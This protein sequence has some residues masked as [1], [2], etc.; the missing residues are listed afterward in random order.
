MDNG[1]TANVVA[2]A[3]AGYALARLLKPRA[4]ANNFTANETERYNRICQLYKD[5]IAPTIPEEWGVT[6]E[7]GHTRPSHSIEEAQDDLDAVINGLKDKDQIYRN[8][9][10]NPMNAFKH[11]LVSNLLTLLDIN[12][13]R[14]QDGQANFLG[15][16]R[17]L[18]QELALPL[19]SPEIMYLSE[20]SIFIINSDFDDDKVI[21]KRINYIDAIHREVIVQSRH[22]HLHINIH[23]TNGLILDAL[24]I[25]HIKLLEAENDPKKL[26]AN[27][28]SGINVLNATAIKVIYSWYNDG[29]QA[30]DVK[31]FLNKKPCPKDKLSKELYDT[32][33]TLGFKTDLF[34]DSSS[35]TREKLDYIKKNIITDAP[36]DV[37]I[38]KPEALGCSGFFANEEDQKEI[39]TLN[40]IILE[41]ISWLYFYGNGLSKLIDAMNKRGVVGLFDENETI[42][43]VLARSLDFTIAECEKLQ[44]AVNRYID[45]HTT[46]QATAYYNET[47]MKL[48]S[49]KRGLVHKL[50]V[51]NLSNNRTNIKQWLQTKHHLQLESLVNVPVQALQLKQSTPNELIS[52]LT[53]IY[54]SKEM[55]CDQQLGLVNLPQDTE[56]VA[57]ELK[58]I[59][60][61]FVQGYAWAAANTWIGVWSAYFKGVHTDEKKLKRFR[62]LWSDTFKAIKQVINRASDYQSQIMGAVMIVHQINDNIK[63]FHNKPSFI[64]SLNHI[65]MQ[66]TGHTVRVTINRNGT[67]SVFSVNA[68]TIPN[69][70]LRRHRVEVQHQNHIQAEEDALRQAIRNQRIQQG[71]VITVPVQAQPIAVPG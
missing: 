3:V 29:P 51:T 15:T 14:L 71:Q 42:G 60:D 10:N 52:H 41:S 23:T 49:R 69:R 9:L 59:F 61:I 20:L 48:W 44:A 43:I 38:V 13:R 70:I 36:D 25:L 21:L 66:K 67:N 6:K 4:G 55:P 16:W 18:Y 2:G 11:T 40:R 58:E 32:L 35:L 24:R 46:T 63:V 22:A 28:I 30:S 34:P 5:Y 37:R 65:T 1:T 47:I 45:M 68:S 19:Q 62:K 12:A 7:G 31:A 33:I 17:Q 64:P 27:I 50:F 39:L 8:H 54:K 56:F 26:T 57:P 53:A